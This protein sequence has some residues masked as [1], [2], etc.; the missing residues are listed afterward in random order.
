[1]SDFEVT[2]FDIDNQKVFDAQN[3]NERGSEISIAQ[4]SNPLT[5]GIHEKVIHT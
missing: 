4:I 5:P 2:G 3:N 1:M